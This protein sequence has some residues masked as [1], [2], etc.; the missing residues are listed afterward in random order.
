MAKLFLS[1]KGKA[2]KN[3][4]IFTQC[5]IGYVSSLQKVVSFAGTFPMGYG[6]ARCHG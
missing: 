1:L 2:E 4:G 6:F 3:C 5:L